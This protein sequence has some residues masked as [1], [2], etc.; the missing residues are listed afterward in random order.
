MRI[1][2]LSTV[3][4][5]IL[6]VSNALASSSLAIGNSG[7]VA[8]GAGRWFDYVVVIMMEN[9]SINNTY[10]VSVAPNS[11]NSN[12]QTC[13]GNCTYFDS[14]ANS[15]GL[16]K[17]YAEDP[18][19]SASASIGSY[20]AITSGYA[21]T[22]PNC[23]ISPPDPSGSCPPLQIPNIVDSLDRAGLTWRAYM[24][25]LHQSSGCVTHDIPDPYNYHFNHN[26]FIYYDDILNNATR[27]SDIVNANLVPVSQTSCLQTAALPNDDVL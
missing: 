26:P 9:H 6:I 13:L 4:V 25:G 24:E 5:A 1:F 16:A 8:A 10:G 14:L 11:W 18:G 23:N 27:C 3:L 20:I 2:P 21:N 15:N 7:L 22:N 17:G 19:Q 12:S